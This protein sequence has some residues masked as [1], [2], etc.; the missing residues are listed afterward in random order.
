[1]KKNLLVILFFVSYLFVHAQDGELLK[2]IG[3]SGPTTEKISGAFK[4]TR[5]INAHS[6]EMLGKGNLD[7]RIMHRFGFI[8]SGINQFFGLD[9]ASMRLS[10]DYGITNNLMAGIG[11]STF[12]K[13][14]DLFVK[15][16]FLQQKKG[17]VNFPFSLLVAAG[18]LV[19]TEKSFTAIKPGFSD[20]SSYYLQ[21]IA[22][23][24]FNTKFSLQISPIVVHSNTPVYPSDDKTIVAL[25]GGARYKITKRLALTLDYH[26]TLGNLD[27]N[28]TDP[29]SVGLDIETGG[30]VFQLQFSNATGMNE[31]AYITQTTGKFFNGD[32]RFGFNLSRM[33]SMNRKHK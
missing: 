8:S 13:E 29:L 17:S 22:G 16:R 20:R 11:R 24:K 27:N 18:Y 30:H 32:I 2:T 15:A 25:G 10:F 21:M 3:D 1:M 7:F 12:R 28:L 33:F 4:S 14:L 31:R 23:R 9:A 5:V 6:L 26:H 19:N